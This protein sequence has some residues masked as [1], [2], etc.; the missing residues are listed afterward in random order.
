MVVAAIAG[1]RPAHIAV[2]V[3][4]AAVA[5]VRPAHVAAQVAVV[6]ALAV[7]AAT[8][9][10]AVAGVCAA[11]IATAAIVPVVATAVAGALTAHAG[12][13]F[14]VAGVGNHTQGLAQHHGPVAAP[15][16]N[17]GGGAGRRAARIKEQGAKADAA[18]RADVAQIG[19]RSVGEL[20]EVS[21]VFCVRDQR[22][23][24][25]GQD[26]LKR[27]SGAGAQP[28]RDKGATFLVFCD[29]GGGGDEQAVAFA[30]DADRPDGCA[31]AGGGRQG[32]G[33]LQRKGG[34]QSKDG[35]GHFG[36]RRPED[37]AALV[38]VEQVI[39]AAH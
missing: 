35:A 31:V 39:A 10:A 1:V 28:C 17:I 33:L 15:R 18:R 9:T 25:H 16:G 8:G 22:V 2:V 38:P 12:I 19:T 7:H 23:G 30:V 14:K 3:M 20:Q 4:A 36:R 5:G 21:P 29:T 24:R 11:H 34:G 32:D 26:I 27:D 37:P 6:L 13:C